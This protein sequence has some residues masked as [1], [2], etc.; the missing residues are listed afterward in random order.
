V[1]PSWSGSGSILMPRTSRAPLT[2]LFALL[3]LAALASGPA[4]AAT[5]RSGLL[6]SVTCTSPHACIGVGSVQTLGPS[7]RD[8][9][10]AE[11][12]NGEAWTILRTAD[13]GGAVGSNLYGVSCTTA[14]A[15]MA[16][17]G[18][19]TRSHSHG[20]LPLA[21][22]WNGHTWKIKATPVVAPDGYL[23]SVSCSAPGACVATGFAIRQGHNNWVSDAWNGR[24]WTV[25]AAPRPNGT[26]FSS[27]DG[28]SCAS[29]SLCIAAGDYELGGSSNSLTLAETWKGG[30]WTTTPS[31]NPA[32]GVNGSQLFG[33]S[34]GS[35]T[36]CMAVGN[37]TTPSNRTSLTLA[38]IWN[39]STW[40]I[41]PG[42]NSR[43]SASSTLQ[44]VWCRAANACMAVG[45]SNSR[46]GN[47]GVILAEAWNGSS[48]TIEPSRTP[49]GASEVMLASVSC[50]SPQ[51]CVA[52]G[53]YF[54]DPR[55]PGLPLTEVW[56]GQRWTIKP[57]PI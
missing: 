40:A 57:T 50:G 45:E 25:R 42:R 15:C 54:T 30:S 43:D 44:G 12:W 23:D 26:T 53:N 22:V 47:R 52:V 13:P 16:V 9:T 32:H 51:S 19:T 3:C 21:E 8:Y 10:R 37:H 17:G 41:T 56:N 55:A 5:N 11:K 28:V 24:S 14:D 33:V 20:S 36:M 6:I 31:P 38:E 34:C 7:G 48:W 46:S 49:R 29:R 18:Y 2:V 35:T 27:I 4:Q 39:G 1:T